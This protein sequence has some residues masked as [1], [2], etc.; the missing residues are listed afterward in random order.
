MKIQ[1]I[2]AY[3][4]VNE[5]G[6]E[7]I[8]GFNDPRTQQWL[9]MIAADEERL[10][11]LKPFAHQIALVTKQQVKLVKFHTREDFDNV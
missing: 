8:C 6:E 7:G 3:V 1:S 11:S 4:S 2:W 9:P 10:K 5:N